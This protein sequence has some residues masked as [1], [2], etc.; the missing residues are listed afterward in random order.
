MAHRTQEEQ[1]H[2]DMNRIHSK[3]TRSETV[4]RKSLWRERINYRNN[5]QLLPGNLI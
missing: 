4:F 5:Y 3:N 1:R 2:Y